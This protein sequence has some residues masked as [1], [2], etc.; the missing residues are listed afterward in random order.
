MVLDPKTLLIEELGN[1]VSPMRDSCHRM[2]KFGAFIPELNSIHCISLSPVDILIMQQSSKLI[3]YHDP[4][5]EFWIIENP[6]I[7]QSI[8]EKNDLVTV[9][10]QEG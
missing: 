7:F 8:K 2:E 5:V 4:K 3:F 6:S 9:G 1:G 10:D